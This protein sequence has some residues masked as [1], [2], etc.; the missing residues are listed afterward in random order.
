MPQLSHQ[1][2]H[3]MFIRPHSVAERIAR[4]LVMFAIMRFYAQSRQSGGRGTRDVLLIVL[5]ADAAQ[6]GLANE[7]TCALGNRVRG[8]RKRFF[9]KIRHSTSSITVCLMS[10][11]TQYKE[12]YDPDRARAVR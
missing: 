11:P 5:L 8:R 10:H 3:N 4:V 2:W 9:W 7:S 12:I 1:V 6:N